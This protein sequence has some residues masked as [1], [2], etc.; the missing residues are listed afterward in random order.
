[1]KL[2]DPALQAARGLAEIN[3][4]FRAELAEHRTLAAARRRRRGGVAAWVILV[5]GCSM[6]GL[7]ATH[8]QR[9]AAIRRDLMDGFNRS[10]VEAP[11][12]RSAPSPPTQPL[13]R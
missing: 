13:I 1:M 11:A 6:A 7:W 9:A 8:S 2:A 12:D 3:E 10:A 4:T 5:A